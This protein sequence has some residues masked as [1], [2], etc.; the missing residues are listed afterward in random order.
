MSGLVI[1]RQVGLLV[2]FLQIYQCFAEEWE[3]VKVY[4]S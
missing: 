4:Y 3:L 1:V 2:T